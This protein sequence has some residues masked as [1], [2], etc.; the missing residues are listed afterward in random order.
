MKKFLFEFVTVFFLYIGAILEA[1][2]PS[3]N[4]SRPEIDALNQRCYNNKAENWDRFPFG[5]ILPKIILKYYPSELGSKALD[6][7]SGT[8]ILAHWLKQQGLSI[9]CLDPSKEMVR[10]CREKGLATVQISIQ[11][12]QTNEK[13]ALVFAMLSLIHVPKLEFSPQIKKIA[14][15]LLPQGIFFLGL[16]EGNGEGIAEQKSQYPRYFSYYTKEEVLNVIENNFKVVEYIRLE[17]PPNYLIFV[18]ANNYGK[19]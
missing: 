3:N 13:F 4:L 16:I 10:R 8:G 2:Q 9:L 18:L 14:A 15:L 6:I 7:G 12:F 11:E 19:P 17:G 1:Q 5:S